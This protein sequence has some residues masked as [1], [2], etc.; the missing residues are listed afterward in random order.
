MVGQ[1]VLRECLLDPQVTRVLVVGRHPTG[2][3]H[4]KLREITHTDFLDFAPIA[5]A[6]T[7]LDACF[8]CLGV[9]SAGLSEERYRQV[10]YDVTMAAATVLAERNPAMTFVYV[11]G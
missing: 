10:T 2:R 6:L 7:G 1:G 9:S 4:P 5:G 8:F 3:E 11:S